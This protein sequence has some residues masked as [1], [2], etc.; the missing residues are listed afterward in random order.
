MAGF[1]A[2]GLFLGAVFIAVPGIMTVMAAVA[3]MKLF[4]LLEIMALA[5]NTKEAE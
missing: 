4:R 1:L 3:L 2:F 5:G